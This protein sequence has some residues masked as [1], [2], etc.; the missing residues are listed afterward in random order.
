LP[1]NPIKKQK[2][3]KKEAGVEL[4]LIVNGLNKFFL[5]WMLRFPVVLCTSFKNLET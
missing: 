1:E 3:E 4:L 2:R 5:F